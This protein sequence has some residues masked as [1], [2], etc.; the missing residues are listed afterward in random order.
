MEIG[1]GYV[2][3]YDS[4]RYTLYLD[5]TYNAHFTDVNHIKYNIKLNNKY[6]KLIN[7]KTKLLIVLTNKTPREITDNRI[8]TFDSPAISIL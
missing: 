8:T 7:Q 1:Y 6:I 3:M 2:S 5:N 4:L